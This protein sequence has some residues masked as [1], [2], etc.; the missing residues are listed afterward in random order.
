MGQDHRGLAEISR[1][2]APP[3]F[4]QRLALL[5]RAYADHDPDRY[6]PTL[7]GGLYCQGCGGRVPRRTGECTTYRESRDALENN[8]YQTQAQEAIQA[9]YGRGH[10]HAGA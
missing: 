2:E 5:R 3:I 1:D 8:Q 7:F 6:I 4:D 9:V 10:Q